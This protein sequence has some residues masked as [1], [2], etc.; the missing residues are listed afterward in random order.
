MHA[1]PVL[2]FKKRLHA[3]NEWGI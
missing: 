3:C 2:T 1:E